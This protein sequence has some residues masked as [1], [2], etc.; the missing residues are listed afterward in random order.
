[1]KTHWRVKR[2]DIKVAFILE[3]VMSEKAEKVVRL[4][5]QELT[6]TE[7]RLS[8]NSRAGCNLKEMIFFF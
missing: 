2:S 7:K 4:E 1:M 5:K 8:T 6:E 3:A